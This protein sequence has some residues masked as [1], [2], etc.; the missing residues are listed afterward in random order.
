MA[1]T[2]SALLVCPKLIQCNRNISD[3]KGK[4]LI[5]LG[6]CFVQLQIGKEHFVMC[7]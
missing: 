6:E 7:L 5:P 1:A 2:H 4:T 3:T